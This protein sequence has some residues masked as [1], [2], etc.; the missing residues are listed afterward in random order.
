M[1]D[2][3]ADCDDGSD[4]TFEVC[5]LITCP[6]FAYKCAY[7]GCIDNNR[8]CNGISDCVDDSDETNCNDKVTGKK[9]RSTRTVAAMKSK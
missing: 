1:C 3:I 9:K 5:S 8:R 4:E 6:G 7:G 2:G